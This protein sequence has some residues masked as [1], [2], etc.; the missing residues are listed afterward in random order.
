LGDRLLVG[1][2]VDQ[3]IE[4]SGAASFAKNPDYFDPAKIVELA[5]EGGCNA[6]ATTFGVLGLT[7]RRYA[8]RI[9]FIVKVNHNELLT[10]PNAADQVMYG[11]VRQAWDLGAAGIG[12]TI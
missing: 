5:I 9:P 2:P 1:P 12:A 7:S 10:Y 8:H 3:G 4:H 6:V 11:S